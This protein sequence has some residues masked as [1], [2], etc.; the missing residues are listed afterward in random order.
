[1]VFD[2]TH[3]HEGGSRTKWSTYALACPQEYSYALKISLNANLRQL[4]RISNGQGFLR[5]WTSKRR[6][7][8][9]KVLCHRDR[10]FPRWSFFVKPREMQPIHQSKSDVVLALSPHP[11]RSVMHSK[12]GHAVLKL[13][14]FPSVT[15]WHP[16]LCSGEWWSVYAA[17]RQT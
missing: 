5:L 8:D 3:R 15:F 7:K 4:I 10:T 1:M 14:L 6:N 13:R 17:V 11:S 2:G 9:T 12:V 16:T